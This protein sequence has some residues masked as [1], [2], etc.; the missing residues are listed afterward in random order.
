M[1]ALRAQ[2]ILAFAVAAETPSTA[3]TVTLVP[4]TLATRI[5]EDATTQRIPMAPLA[6]VIIRLATTPFVGFGGAGPVNASRGVT[7]KTVNAFEVQP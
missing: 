6:D 3:M 5:P 1:T 7:A 2:M 4:K